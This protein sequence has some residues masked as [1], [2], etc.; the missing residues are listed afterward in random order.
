MKNIYCLFTL[1]LGCFFLGQTIIVK[2]TLTNNPLGSVSVHDL[3]G[4]LLVVTDY[5][6][7]ASLD[8]C[9]SESVQVSLEEYESIILN[10][11][12]LDRD[13]SNIVFLK[14]KTFKL[15]AVI[16][17]G[18]KWQHSTQ[19]TPEH[20]ISLSS[21]D[22]KFSNSQTT[23]DLL[24]SS[25][26]VFIQKSQQGGGS[27]MI[28][29]FATNRLQIV[30]DGIKMNNAIFR[31]G[32]IQNIIAIDPFTL[33]NVD[34]IAGPGSVLYGS[35]AIGGVMNFETKE[36]YP[37]EKFHLNGN[38]VSRYSSASNEKTAHASLML[39]NKK[40]ATFTS[41]S[42]NDFDDLKMG[43][44]GPKDYLRPEYVETV[45]NQDFIVEN[46]N[47][48]K[49]KHS[50]YQQKNVLQ[51]V[52]FQPNDKFNIQYSFS[53]AE[54]SN[55]P[56]YD[57]LTRYRNGELRSA[58]W[59]YG[60]QEWAVN[61]LML[62]FKNKNKVYDEFLS[63]IS[64]QY[65]TESRH[66]RNLNA[67]KRRNRFEKVN[68]WSW[69][70]NFIKSLNPKNK[71][72]YGFDMNFNHV[73]SWANKE[74]IETGEEHK[75]PS[76]YPN[77]SNWN[78]FGA[79]T[80]WLNKLSG[81]ISLESGVRYSFINSTS[82]FND[83]FY[84]FSFNN[85]NYSTNNI[86]GNIGASMK[87]PHKCR[88]NFHLATGFR[89]P[90]IDDISKIFDSEPGNVVVPNPDLKPERI[91]SVET[92]LSKSYGKILHISVNAYYSWLSNA[93]IRRDYTLNG[94]THMIY[95]GELSQI[96]ALQ[97]ASKAIVYG[98]NFSMEL[99]LHKHFKFLGKINYT[100]GEE[101]LE[102]GTMSSLRHS[103]PLFGS[104]SIMYE[105][106]SVRLKL[107]TLFNGKIEAEDLP[108]SE[109]SKDYIYA[110]NHDGLPYVPSWL[111]LNFN[112]NVKLSDYVSLNLG[113]ENIFDKR[114]RPYSS[115][116]SAPGRNFVISVQTL[117]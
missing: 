61:A 67:K 17:S 15:E 95:D 23:A 100:H 104:T 60:P 78:Q 12:E 24:N 71:L 111:I 9:K 47:P 94:E 85:A 8:K 49:Q 84:P 68:V 92:G 27:P 65:F 80:K 37:T 58:E 79:Y 106:K 91:Y 98:G 66:D 69:D 105:K 34:V 54:T 29:G 70:N 59:Y 73:N 64:H 99:N 56:R 82:S 112:S 39:S 115:G 28:R 42:I 117:F 41:F 101:E 6:G 31:S 38:I 14:P 57:R 62:G 3:D 16:I 113:I 11:T 90:N 103:A 4:K 26:E 2:D 36:I 44:H 75:I 77:G 63:T 1:L 87:F 48:K 102:D 72:F 93:L 19:K 25:G 96:Q 76:R 83:D 89:A 55:V 33:S 107:E 114:Y 109:Q 32:N 110:L 35:D 43:S 88:L 50:G 5:S 51:K 10:L 46:S 13:K 22:I 52:K 108:I 45:N 53:F 116:I 21:K 18:A 74:N 20:I 81:T 86:S 40:W 97:N 30:V 7:K